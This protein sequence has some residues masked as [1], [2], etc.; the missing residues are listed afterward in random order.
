M[1]LV[2]LTVDIGDVCDLDCSISKIPPRRF[3]NEKICKEC[4]FCVHLSKSSVFK[5]VIED[6]PQTERKKDGRKVSP[7]CRIA[8]DCFAALA[9][10]AFAIKELHKAAQ[11]ADSIQSRVSVFCCFFFRKG[12][13]PVDPKCGPCQRGRMA[14]QK[15]SVATT[16]LF[17]QAK[18]SLQPFL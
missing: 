12:T 17:S 2:S 14:E 4:A 7:F 16:D 6:I 3:S 15:R 1:T 8:R 5:A 18:K 9:G 11:W 10:K 13:F